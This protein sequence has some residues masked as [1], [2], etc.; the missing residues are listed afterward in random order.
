MNW[1]G[2]ICI[3]IIVAGGLYACNDRGGGAY[4]RIVREELAK[5]KRSDSLLMGIKFGMTGKEFFA[6]CWE[7]NKKGLFTDGNNN[8]AVLYK[9]DK[10]FPQRVHMNFYPTFDHDRIASLTATFAYEAWAPWNHALFS[11]SLLPGVLDLYRKWFPGNDF[12][13]ISDPKKGTIY[14]KVDN[15]RRIIV[16]RHDDQNVNVDYTDLL[17]ERELKK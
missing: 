17:V 9:I 6:Y 7:M 2:P 16:G 14:V 10:E 13:K 1:K 12:L 8:T 15:N 11:D 3:L 4:N 5:H